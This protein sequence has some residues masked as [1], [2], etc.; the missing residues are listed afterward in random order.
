MKST[1][2]LF[3]CLL[4][5]LQTSL[6]A[7]EMETATAPQFL[8]DAEILSIRNSDVLVAAR[9][10]FDQVEQS[11]HF[12]GQR[13]QPRLANRKQELSI[14]QSEVRHF[15]LNAISVS[16]VEGESL[17]RE[18]LKNALEGRPAVLFLPRGSDLHPAIRAILRPDALI[19]TFRER[20]MPSRQT[21]PRP[22][23]R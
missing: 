3:A 20:G 11:F 23:S 16:T 1:P 6:I 22:V 18:D 17:S 2:L 14:L 13:D 10:Y 12:D 9:L 5:L 4:P 19:V 7:D 21:V 8:V 15:Y